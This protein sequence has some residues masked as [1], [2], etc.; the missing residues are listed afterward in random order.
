[1]KNLKISLLLSALVLATSSY[2]ETTNNEEVAVNTRD[3]C[4]YYYRETLSHP[5][6]KR[7]AAV[8]VNKEAAQ[9]IQL[10]RQFAEEYLMNADIGSFSPT[11]ANYDFE[12][13]DQI[14]G[15]LSMGDILSQSEAV[16]ELISLFGYYYLG[17]YVPKDDYQAI[18]YLEKLVE[19]Y[20]TTRPEYVDELILGVAMSLDGGISKANPLWTNDDPTQVFNLL[21]KAGSIETEAMMIDEDFDSS[22]A[23]CVKNMLP[24][25]EALADQGSRL[26]IHRL[27]KYYKK[28]SA[29]GTEAD[30]EKMMYWQQKA[31]ENPLIGIKWSI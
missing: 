12:D 4:G 30:N 25:L 24:K 21:I 11:G 27:E 19:Y 1:M 3:Q 8:T 10:K 22:D 5:V 7:D 13:S 29:K 26:A 17:E 23:D 6:I 28:L 2:A 20:K 16:K 14:L 15:A 31:E 9:Y 18:T